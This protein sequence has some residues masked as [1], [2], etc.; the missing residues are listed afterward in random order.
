MSTPTRTRNLLALAACALTGCALLGKNQPVVPRYFSPLEDGQ[1]A[2]PRAPRTA[3]ELR[4]GK[5]EGW[6]HVRQRMAMRHSAQELVFAEGRLWTEKPEVYLRRALSAALFEERGVVE[7]LAGRSTTLDV[8]LSAFEEVPQAP[9][10]V[11]LE[12]IYTLRD[13]EGRGL[14]QETLSL[15]Q[16]VREA[17]GDELAQAIVEAFGEVLRTSVAQIANRVLHKLEADASL[18]PAPAPKQR[19]QPGAEWLNGAD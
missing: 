8:E 4:L 2:A 11:R 13:D 19:V 9:G 3:Y 14:Q 6:S 10:R 1:R 16:V 15:E 18:R 5:V 12:A 17:K 7:V